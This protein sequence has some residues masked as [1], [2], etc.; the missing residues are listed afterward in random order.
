[1]NEYLRDQFVLWKWYMITLEGKVDLQMSSFR[2]RSRC[3]CFLLFFVQS[4]FFTWKKFHGRHDLKREFSSDT[5][6]LKSFLLLKR[7]QHNTKLLPLTL[8]LKIKMQMGYALSNNF[9]DC[10]LYKVSEIVVKKCNGIFFLLRGF[11]S[12]NIVCLVTQ[13]PSMFFPA[14]K[15]LENIS[16]TPSSPFS[17]WF[18]QKLKVN[19]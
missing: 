12:R 17:K 6:T 3:K 19:I 5:S 2:E 14:I 18:F 8:L 7:Y 4:S 9:W 13:D 1:M 16:I 10:V 11:C 15:A